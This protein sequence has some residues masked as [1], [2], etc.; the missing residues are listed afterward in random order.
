M[1]A[2]AFLSKLSEKYR[3]SGFYL[4]ANLLSSP[5]R[6]L[7]HGDRAA[8]MKSLSRG[9][10]HLI[11]E[12]RRGAYEVDV[13]GRDLVLLTLVQDMLLEEWEA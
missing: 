4:A 2:L 7:E 3:E 5:L 8:A 12:M 11:T 1:T 9:K 13:Y 6:H 10:E